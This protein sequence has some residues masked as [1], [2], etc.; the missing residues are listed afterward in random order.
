MRYLL[1]TCVLSELVA[2]QPDPGVVQWIAD[3]DEE[4]LYLSVISIGEIAKG[5]QKLPDSRRKDMLGRW[6]REDL[7][8]RFRDRI[9]S[10]DTN[11]MLAWGELVATL[12]SQGRPMPAIDSLV[13]AIALQG[14]FTLVTRNETDCEASSVAVINPWKG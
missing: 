9:L 7:L 8:I 4:Q 14:G 1:D 12:E 2:R 6:L 10:I 5:I 3:K 11:T 13:A